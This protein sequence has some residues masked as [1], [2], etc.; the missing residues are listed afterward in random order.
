MSSLLETPQAGRYAVL[1]VDPPWRYAMRSDLGR[2]KAPDAHY[3]CMDLDALKALPVAEVAGPRCFLFMW[4]TWAFLAA[5]HAHALAEAWS[6]PADPWRGVSGGSWHKMTAAGKMAF[7]Q[8]YI[9]RTSSEPILLF[10]KGDPKWHSRRE[11][12]SW[13]GGA[14]FEALRREHSRKPDPV[15][16]MI[17][18]ATHGPRLEMFTR[19]NAEGWDAWGDQAGLFD[20]AE[21]VAALKAEKAARVARRA[22]QLELGL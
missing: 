22:C 21:A 14:G 12:N 4:T 17:E 10:A 15:R 8:G 19:S 9:F 3:E 1:Y 5:G 16:D 20:D 13:T 6:D 7:G 18:R 2:E 11:R